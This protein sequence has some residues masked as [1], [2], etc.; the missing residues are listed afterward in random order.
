LLEEK[1][2]RI[3]GGIIL[4]VGVIISFADLWYSTEPSDI[5]QYKVTISD[6]V[7]MVE[8]NEKYDVI[9]VEGKIYTIRE[10][11]DK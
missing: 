11:E 8:F 10:K 6:S 9:E 1:V 5:K 7:S 3:I 2:L 4:A